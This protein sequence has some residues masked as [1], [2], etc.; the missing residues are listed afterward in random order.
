[1][2]TPCFQSSIVGLP[3]DL[4]VRPVQG[5]QL[6]VEPRDDDEIVLERDAAMDRPAAQHGVEALLIFRLIAPEDVAGLA[7][8]PRRRGHSRRVK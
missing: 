8:R 5:D 7:R 4:A 1:M 3:D 2:V 6:G